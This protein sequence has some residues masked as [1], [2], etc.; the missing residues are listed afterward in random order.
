MLVDGDTFSIHGIF[1]APEKNL[2]LILVK[3]TQDCA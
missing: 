2:V 1:A 3:Q